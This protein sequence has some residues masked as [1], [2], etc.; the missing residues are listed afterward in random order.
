MPHLV[1]EGRPQCAK[2][3][4]LAVESDQGRSVSA[5][6]R[7]S[8]GGR[9]IDDRQP[10]VT[11]NHDRASRSANYLLATAIRPSVAQTLDHAC[12]ALVGRG[13]PPGLPIDAWK[14]ESRDPT[15]RANVSRT[16]D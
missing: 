16:L 1:S 14:E 11:Q 8:T 4:N 13:E 3:V 9:R 10:G 6:H 7:L 15:H 12:H 5:G 2:V